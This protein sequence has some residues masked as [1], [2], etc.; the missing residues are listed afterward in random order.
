MR[1]VGK[2]KGRLDLRSSAGK[3]LG[4]VTRFLRN[5]A[6]LPEQR[7]I[8][9]PL[10]LKIQR[11]QR[12]VVPDNG[13][14]LRSFLRRPE[15]SATTATPAATATTCRTPATAFAGAASNDFIFPPNTG[16]RTITAVSMPGTRT[17]M[18]NWAWPVTFAREST[19]CAF[20]R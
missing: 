8:F 14:R 20:S 16:D 1:Q 15:F 17:S 2:L 19:R 11:G 4:H 12:T 9:R 5:R 7:R 3:S 18:P 6:R 13:Q 10:L